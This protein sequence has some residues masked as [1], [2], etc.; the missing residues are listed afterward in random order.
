MSFIIARPDL[1][2]STDSRCDAMSGSAWRTSLSAAICLPSAI[3]ARL[4]NL[5]AFAASPC[6]RYRSACADAA[7]AFWPH[8][9][10]AATSSL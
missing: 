9:W 8:S 5:S 6:W 3:F 10:T 2:F 1:S 4:S 7:A